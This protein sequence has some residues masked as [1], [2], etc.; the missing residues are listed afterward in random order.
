MLRVVDMMVCI[1]FHLKDGMNLGILGAL[2][3]MAGKSQ[4]P[5]FSANTDLFQM[6]LQTTKVRY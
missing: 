3:L 2:C 5:T 6:S 4:I 1:L